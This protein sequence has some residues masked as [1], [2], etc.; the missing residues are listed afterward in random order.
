MILRLVAG[1]L[2]DL[3]AAL[4]DGLAVFRVRRRLDRG[5]NGQIDAERLV[6][7]A[8][9]ACDFFRQILGRRLRQRGDKAERAGIGDRGHQFGASHP[10]H[11][12]LHDRVF[13]PDERGKSGLDHAMPS[14]G[15]F[16]ARR[17]CRFL[18]FRGSGMP[19]GPANVHRAAHPNGQ[20]DHA[21]AGVFAATA[22]SRQYS[23]AIFARCA[24]NASTESSAGVG[25]CVRRPI[26]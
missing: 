7:Q 21:K 9:A 13:D 11:A 26:S 17:A 1:G 4:D 10:L 15:F 19:S 14:E 5:K 2:H 8:A 18:F 3:D 24:I 12:A 22:R 23:P 25:I 20:C 16:R 6:G